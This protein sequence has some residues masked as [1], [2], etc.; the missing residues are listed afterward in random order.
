MSSIHPVI[1]CGGS[2]TRLWPRSRPARP[3]PFLDLLGGRTLFQRSLDRV[4]G[5][6]RFAPPLIV[7][8]AAHV[9]AIEEQ[10]EKSAGAR[11]LIEPEPRNT[12]PAIALAAHAL[13]PDD[14]MLVCP[15]AVSY[16]HLTLPTKRIV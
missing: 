11:L 2:G 1:L 15:S 10:A 16:T 6:A 7:A 13:A 4:G 3:K 8:G 14:I 5:P 9:A 12:A